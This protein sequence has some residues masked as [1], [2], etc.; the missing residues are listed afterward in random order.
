MAFDLRPGVDDFQGSICYIY[1]YLEGYVT[2]LMQLLR[3]RRNMS[4]HT[5]ADGFW[6]A[7]SSPTNRLIYTVT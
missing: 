4:R 3:R 7:M 1:S 6:W 2:V 5:R